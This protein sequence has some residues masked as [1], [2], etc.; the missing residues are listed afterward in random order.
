[1]SSSSTLPNG[2]L[3]PW[4]TWGQYG[5]LNFLVQQALAKLQTSTLVEVMACTNDGDVSPVGFVDI[6]PLVNQLDGDGNSFPHTTI[7]NVPY[8]RV[9]SSNGNGIILDPSV[10]DIGFALFASRDI[11]AVIRT[12][13]GANPGSARKFDFSDAMYVGGLVNGGTPSQYIQ[14]N[15]EGITI[16]SPSK[17]T[18]QAPE[19]DLIGAVNQTMGTM[20]VETDIMA[21]TSSV[22]LIGH[23]HT[24]E[25]VGDPTSP[26]IP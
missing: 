17:I 8:Q 23:T 1:M 5:Q 16:V 12:Q 4:S 26:P 13:A 18:L 22:S 7:Y 6:R 3:T 19:I 21:G 10:G 15:D 14:F 25:S 20:T 2:V 9:Q 24:S 11:S